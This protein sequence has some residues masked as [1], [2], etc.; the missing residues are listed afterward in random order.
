[1]PVSNICLKFHPNNGIDYLLHILDKIDLG[2]FLDD[3]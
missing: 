3:Q 2:Q 1:M